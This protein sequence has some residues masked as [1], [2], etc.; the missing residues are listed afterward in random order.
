MVLVRSAAGS[1]IELV[2]PEVAATGSVRAWP[3]AELSLTWHAEGQ[4]SDTSGGG[5]VPASR[6]F[7]R[8]TRPEGTLTTPSVLANCEATSVA[9][10]AKHGREAMHEQS[11][12]S[13]T[14]IWRK[15]ER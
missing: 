6:S 15:R 11:D 9:S 7:T 13:A 3:S 4:A 12:I 1:V 14:P 2:L 8:L 5:V 10:S